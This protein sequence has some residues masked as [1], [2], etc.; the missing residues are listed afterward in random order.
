MRKVLQIGSWIVLLVYFLLMTS[1]VSK[2]HDERICSAVEVIITDSSSHKFVSSDDVKVLLDKAG[3]VTLG[4]P[5]ESINTQLVEQVL[6]K[7][8]LIEACNAYTTIDG[9]L[10]LEIYQKTP[11]LKILAKNGGT[12]FLDSSGDIFATSSKYNPHI[13]IASGNIDIPEKLRTNKNIFDRENYQGCSELRGLY[14]LITYINQSDFWEAQIEQIYRTKK[15]EY[16]LVP[17]VGP[18][19]I[20]F[21][22]LDDY[23][24]KL[25]KLDMLY[26]EGFSRVGWNGYL[27]INLK[28]KDQIVCTKN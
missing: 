25:W 5:V 10:F 8:D 7:D 16:E 21:G 3:I 26:R 24:E 15:G 13:I 22:S 19:L 18:H 17:R 23:E 20:Q 27:Y 14:N 11:V 12:Y 28:Y 1:F 4:N 6:L 9:S 2:R